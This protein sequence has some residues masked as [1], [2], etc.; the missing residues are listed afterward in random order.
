MSSECAL[1]RRRGPLPGVRVL[2]KGVL[3]SHSGDL[4]HSPDPE[5][6]EFPA[7]LAPAPPRPQEEEEL[8]KVLRP[9]VTSFVR[10]GSPVSTLCLNYLSFL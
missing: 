1:P 7:P 2:A 10:P 3:L 4:S 8:L 5:G 6:T 9:C